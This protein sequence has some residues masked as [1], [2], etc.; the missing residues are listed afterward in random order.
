MSENRYK[1]L[2]TAGGSPGQEALYRDLHDRYVMF[3]ADMDPL[4]ISPS[5]PATQRFQIPAATSEDFV[6]ALSQLCEDLGVDLLVPGVDEELLQIWRAKEMFGATRLFMPKASFVEEM[7]DKLKMNRIFS[8]LGLDVPCAVRADESVDGLKFPVLVKPRWGRGSRD[9]YHVN[10]PEKL[11]F[12]LKALDGD[13][14][15]WLVQECIKGKEYTVQIVAAADSS[16]QVIL[17]IHALEKRGSTTVAAMHSDPE[18]ECYCE[19]I[20]R[21]LEPEGCYNV[22]LIKTADGRVLCFEV[23]PRISTTF[24]MVIRAG[25]DPF[26]F[27]CEGMSAENRLGRVPDIRLVRHWI[28]EF[29]KA[30]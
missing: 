30:D 5:I 10:T 13:S 17:P 27:F 8:N 19:D 15:R 16:L 29:V 14:S 18:I 23:N 20:H 28:N 26:K 9:I 7:T 22:Q 24:C 2:F 25:F 11:P 6:P 4:R 21:H 3:F 12:L 1:I